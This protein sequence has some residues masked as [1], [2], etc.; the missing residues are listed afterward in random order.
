MWWLLMIPLQI[1]TIWSGIRQEQREGLWSWSKFFF[2]LGFGAL[3]FVILVAPLTYLDPHRRSFFPIVIT[4]I[5]IAALNF[6]WMIIVA[7]RWRLPDGRTS[8]EAWC[9]V[10]GKQVPAELKGRK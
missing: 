7:R 5:V 10:H 4:S 9:E 2:A 6:V 1:V 8:I 3:E